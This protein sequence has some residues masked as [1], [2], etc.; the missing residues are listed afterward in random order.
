MSKTVLVTGS[1]VFQ[2]RQMVFAVL[3]LHKP[4]IVIHGN[5]RGAD[6]LAA[7]WCRNHPYVYEVAVPA[8]WNLLGRNAGPE[9][10]KILLRLNPQIVLAFFRT[11][12]ENRG[13]KVTVSLAQQAGIPVESFW[14]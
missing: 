10:N 2:D 4:S 11:S 5:A 12:A 1:R 14:S 13:T 7:E 6:S 8:K 3:K 9:R